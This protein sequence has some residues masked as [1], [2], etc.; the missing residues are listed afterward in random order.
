MAI[1][2]F[3]KEKK[4]NKIEFNWKN[5]KQI[6]V[7]L[8]VTTNVPFIK[9]FRKSHIKLQQQQPQQHNQR[10]NDE[11]NDFLKEKK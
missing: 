6:E 7:V 3:M 10:I 2:M 4:N 9:L 8:T 5:T 11:D 1:F